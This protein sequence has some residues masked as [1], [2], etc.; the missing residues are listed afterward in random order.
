LRT[1]TTTLR[2]TGCVGVDGEGKYVS[3][4]LN[5]LKKDQQKK[6]TGMT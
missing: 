2:I 5:F 3:F 4:V 1:K 6:D